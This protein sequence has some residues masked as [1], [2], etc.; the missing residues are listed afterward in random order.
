MLMLTIDSQIWI[1]YWNPN[2]IE[3]TNVVKWLRGKKDDGVLFKETIILSFIILIEIGHVLFKKCVTNKELNKDEIEEALLSL[4]SLENCQLVD[5]NQII[6]I[7]TIKNMKQYISQGIG[8]RDAL[9]LAT[10]EHVDVQTIATHDKNLLAL[11][12][13]KRIDPVFDP[14]LVLDIGKEFD[15]KDFH[16]KIEQLH[17]KK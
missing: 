7:E 8:G 9:I 12:Q 10:M 3:Y 4:L 6:V 13:F 1:Y 2:A 17:D 15:L 5:I 11:T 16:T 14:P